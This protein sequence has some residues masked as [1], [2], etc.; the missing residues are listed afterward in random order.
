V[1]FS[2]LTPAGLLLALAAVVP[3]AA[4]W[5]NERRARR[6]R[7]A[8]RVAAPRAHSQLVTAALLAA[9]PLLLALALAQPV[10]RSTR[11]V[12]TRT[13]AQ[14]FYTFDTSVSMDA[15]SGPHT[16][17]RLQ[18]S[19]A[20][21]ARMRLDLDDV[22]SGVATMTDRVLPNIFPTTDQQ[23]FSSALTD[24]VDIDAPPPKGLS[25]Q[26]T[27][28]AALDTFSGNNFFTPGVAHRLVVLFTDGET[29]PYFP[30]DLR[31]SLRQPPRT[32]LVV[33]HVW[34]AGERIYLGRKPDPDYH[35]DPRS[36]RAVAALA[37]ALGGRAVNEGDVAGAVADARA[38][39]G[40]GTVAQ[41]GVGL[42]VIALSRWLVLL[43][44]VPLAL[45]LWRRNL[46]R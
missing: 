25:D 21:A 4:L 30:A 3:L 29:A 44:L 17:T 10:L 45:L 24:T 7:R 33:V 11:T 19:V 16:P 12:K 8:L 31:Q 41:L 6:V 32:Q 14:V 2:F 36:G 27:T 23:E 39:L 34:R 20:E 37:A 40:P 5:L 22:P 35:S 38:L 28:F 15:S 43:A 26:A 9:V 18:R 42:R 13:D 1:H 46:A